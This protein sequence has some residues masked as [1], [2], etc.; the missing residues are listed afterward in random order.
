MFASNP[1]LIYA[2]LSLNQISVVVSLALALADVEKLEKFII[3]NNLLKTIPSNM[4]T[5]N[6]ELWYVDISSA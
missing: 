1:N 6:A 2:D 4:F 5:N 3:S